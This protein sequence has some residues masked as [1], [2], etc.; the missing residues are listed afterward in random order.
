VAW[1]H[2]DDDLWCGF[3][4]AVAHGK[5][6][7][8]GN[9]LV[10]PE[11][12]GAGIGAQLFDFAICELERQ[13]VNT[14]W[15]TASVQGAPLYRR[16]GFLEYGNIVRWIRP[17]GFWAQDAVVDDHEAHPLLTADGLVWGG[18]RIALLRA[19]CRFGRVLKIGES[20]ALLQYG[21][22]M[23]MIGPWLTATAA[24]EDAESLL[25]L[26]CH[27]AQPDVELV[28]DLVES[29]ASTLQLSSHGFAPAGTNLLMARGPVDACG[30]ATLTALASLGSIG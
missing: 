7:W 24:T 2:G 18:E 11:R 13:G 29:H 15:L 9:L 10:A 8:I 23:Q 30:L 5:S 25:T 20:V 6:G 3:V 21:R 28:V 17:A 19:L 22:D 26:A 4:T 14:I 27:L 16:R 1:S 12:R